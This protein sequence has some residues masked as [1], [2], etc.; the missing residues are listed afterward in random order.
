MK[1]EEFG[2]TGI[3]A[4]HPIMQITTETRW[5]AKWLIGALVMINIILWI[6]A[7]IV[8]YEY[9]VLL[10]PALLCYTLGLRH[11][12][13]AD[14]IAAIDNITRKMM[15]E[16]RQPISIGLFFSLGHSS[17]VVLMSMAVVFSASFISSHLNW[18]QQIGSIIGTTVSCMFLFIIGTINFVIFLQLVRSLKQQ[19]ST[20]PTEESEEPS[21][22]VPS[23]GGCFSSLYPRLFA[24]IDSPFKMFPLGF[25]FGL[26]FD[27]AS[28]V[29][30]LGMAAIA[31]EQ[32]HL[33]SCVILILPL[34]FTAAMSLID[35]LDG[36]LMLWVYGWAFVDPSRKIFYNLFLTGVS[37]LIAYVIG[38]IEA[39][40]VLIEQF[41]WKGQ[42]WETIHT[43]SENFEL[44][45]FVIIGLFMLAFGMSVLWYR[46]HLSRR[47]RA[48]YL[49][50]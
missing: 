30:L 41:G 36:I 48:Q 33:P 28:E 2:N 34:L 35:T 17:V 14:H 18:S 31:H 27:T 4:V 7:L 23:P 15:N 8:S 1:F 29:A 39:L 24:Y 32:H 25:L 49:A 45:G 40:G 9:P 10:S 6:I 26:G 43:L 42:V 19:N 22:E 20:Q 44:I 50:I 11:A 3:E 47:K 5:Q 38:A 46:I 37:A 21:M 12:V 13:D 16:D